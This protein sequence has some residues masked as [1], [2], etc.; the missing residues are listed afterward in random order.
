MFALVYVSEASAAFEGQALRDLAAQAATKNERLGITGYL[1]HARERRTF[2]QY[3]EGAPE[4]VRALMDEI[5]SDPRHDVLNVLELGEVGLRHFPGWSMRHVPAG[6][7]RA[8]RLEEVLESVLKTMRAPAFDAEET[9]PT[10]LRIVRQLAARDL[11]RL[12]DG[13]TGSVRTR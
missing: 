11:D 7:I 9:R 3:L 10:V 4:A 8:V 5:R 13:A 1:H 2:F 6:A 12:P